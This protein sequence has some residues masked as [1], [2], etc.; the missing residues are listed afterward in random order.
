M[1]DAETKE[2]F[3]KVEDLQYLEA[4]LALISADIE[5]H[6]LR[7]KSET[8]RIAYVGWFVSPDGPQ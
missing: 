1:R 6:N 3:T 7:V 2:I 5:H 8:P 4:T